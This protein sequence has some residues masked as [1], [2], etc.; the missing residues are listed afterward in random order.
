MRI[1]A[2][3]Y[4]QTSDPRYREAFLRGLRFTLAA[5]YENGGWPQFYPNPSGYHAHITFNDNAMIGVMRILREIAEGK[6]PFGFVE[7][8]LRDRCGA[9]VKKGIDCILKCQ[10]EVNGKKTAWCAQHDSKTLLPAAA[11]SYELA[12]ISG[13][14]SVG[15]VEF[16]MQTENPDENIIDAVESAVAWFREAQLTGIE[17]VRK[18]DPSAPRGWDKVVVQNP[19]APPIWARFYEIGTNQPIFCSRDGI[20]RRHLSEISYERRT[21][22]S[23]LGQYAA[24]LLER[25][26]PAWK[27]NMTNARKAGKNYE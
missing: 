25:D 17:E 21:G 10:I 1:L 19:D 26:Y 4:Q 9:A 20:P 6:E 12:S 22:Y 16:L 2:E 27:Q 13:S 18:E 3:T 11:R 8:S 7:P 15:I 23:W 14:E 24:R 5:Q